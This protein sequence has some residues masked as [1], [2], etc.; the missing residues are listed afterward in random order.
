MSNSNIYKNQKIRGLKRKLEI[1]NSLGGGCSICKYDK[2]LS[3][4]EFHHLN[5]NKKSFK[6]D[7]RKLANT[8]I[9]LITEELKKCIL[10]CSNCHREI[11]NVGLNKE[12]YLTFL[13]SDK[14][15]FSNP[16]VIKQTKC[17]NCNNTFKKSRGKKFCS[18]ECYY[19][20]KKYPTKEKVLEL[21]KVLKSWDK[22]AN[23]FNLTRK[24]IQ[25]IRKK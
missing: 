20:D 12:N 1:V 3:A 24:I 11:H 14:L 19:N 7:L 17:L 9:N 25:N 5:P 10:V 4:L 23:N 21:Y 22:V 15:S 18:N 8:E 6:L 16:K 13:E 2:N